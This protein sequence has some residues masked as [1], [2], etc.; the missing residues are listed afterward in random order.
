MRR[1]RLRE[2]LGAI[3]LRLAAT[4]ENEPTVEC[5]RTLFA[6]AAG[7]NA[8]SIR[9]TLDDVAKPHF[10]VADEAREAHPIWLAVPSVLSLRL[11]L[12]PSHG[13]RSADGVL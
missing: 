10:L 8:K 11:P 5:P 13:I 4:R 3:D 9:H 1:E 7:L 6:A 2:A 12:S